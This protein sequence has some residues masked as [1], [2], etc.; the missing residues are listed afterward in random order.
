MAAP[1][2]TPMPASPHVM[3]GGAVAIGPLTAVL[4]EGWMSVPP[5][6]SMR[7]AQFSIAPA[8]GDPEPGEV[9]A[10]YFG[11]DAGGVEANIQRWF[12]QFERADGRPLAEV[13]A[14]EEMAVGAMKVTLVS[15]T[16]RIK[17]SAMAGAPQTPTRDGWMN[18]SAIVMTP[19]GP[20]F[21]KGAGPEKTMTAN[22]GT[23]KQFLASLKLAG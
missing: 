22:R 13:A 10:F 2:T 20:W 9:S 19:Q 5:A 14:R 11:P 21:F 4:P 18:L 3:P 6:S 17:A 16:G 15:F 8:A 12:G 7:V 23:M 1:M